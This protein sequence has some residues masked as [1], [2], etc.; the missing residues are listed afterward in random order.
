MNASPFNWR[1]TPASITFQR[2]PNKHKGSPPPLLHGSERNRTASINTERD[3]RPTGS[4]RATKGRQ[5]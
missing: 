3:I 4:I 1:G 5:V 2:A